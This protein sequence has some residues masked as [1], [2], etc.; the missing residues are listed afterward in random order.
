MAYTLEDYKQAEAEAKQAK[1][2]FDEISM[3]MVE[4]LMG[5]NVKTEIDT[6]LGIE[7]RV[8]VVASENISF[9]EDGLLKHLGKRAFARVAN[10]KLDRKK[11]EAAVRDGSISPE[12]VSG[13]SVISR[14]SPY[15]RVTQYSGE[16]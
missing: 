5:R 14:K 9:D 7:W 4:D 12:V 11:L 6:A 15:L 13:Y 10:L 2:R 3:S 16:D 8:T 1:A